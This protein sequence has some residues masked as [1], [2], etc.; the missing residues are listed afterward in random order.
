MAAKGLMPLSYRRY[1]NI[2]DTELTA[3]SRAARLGDLDPVELLNLMVELSRRSHLNQL[4]SLLEFLA[5][6]R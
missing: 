5:D 1:T 4:S 2:S 6:L 3:I